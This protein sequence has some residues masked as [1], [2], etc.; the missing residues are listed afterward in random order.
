V[1]SEP[2]DQ[3]AK[4]KNKGRAGGRPVTCDP[5][6]YRERNTVERGINKIKAWRGLGEAKTPPTT[7]P[8]SNSVPHSSGSAASNPTTDHNTRQALG[9]DTMRRFWDQ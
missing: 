7:R 3:A 5:D 4:R 8:D 2:R 6:L 9:S 1:I